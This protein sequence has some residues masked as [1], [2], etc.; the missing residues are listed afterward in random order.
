[1]KL[2]SD[3]V[4][5]EG[6]RITAYG[7]GFVTVNDTTYRGTVLL[8]QGALATDFDERRPDDLSAAT[9][10][11]LREQAP[12]VV[13]IGTGSRHVFPSPGLLAPLTR[14]GIGVEVMSTSAACR[15]YN[16]LDAEGRAV[17]AL[18]L[19]IEEREC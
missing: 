5:A 11:R 7:G 8:G 19:P 2:H 6:M 12:E 15:T 1:M 14:A 9:I 13:I 3:R 16:I 18:L 10:E 17:V 4:N